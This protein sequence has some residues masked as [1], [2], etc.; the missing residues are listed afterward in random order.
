MDVGFESAGFKIDLACELNKVAA[1]TFRTNFDTPLHN[2]DIRDLIPTMPTSGIDAIFGGPPCQGYSVA[3]KLNADDPRSQLVFSFLEAVA[4]VRP[5]VFV[6]ENVDALAKL[7]KWRG[8]LEDIVTRAKEIGYA[9]HVEIVNAADYNVPQTRKRVLIWGSRDLDQ[10]TL[11]M[12]VGELLAS[13]KRPHIAVREVIERFGPAGSDANPLTA[14]AIITYTK[15]PVLRGSA[16]SGMLFN[17]RGRQLDPSKP[18]LTIAAAA[19]G[20]HTHIIDEDQVFCDQPSFVEEYLDEIREKGHPRT[21]RAP[22]R[23]RRLT[24]KESMA[25]Q[26][27]P[28]NFQFSGKP[29]AIYRQIGNAVPCELAKVAAIIAVSIC[30][31]K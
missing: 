15:N 24:I 31:T 9:V 6:M 30:C 10:E 12:K 25:I 19:G 18:S 17:G 8:T 16:Y 22:D 3:G 23:L 7:S 5:K 13:L 2:G 14:R 11:S 20:N 27:F 21:G 1:Q 26:T 4:R 29:T 28:D